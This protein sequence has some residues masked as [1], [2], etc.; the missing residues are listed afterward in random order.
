[1]MPRPQDLWLSAKA[2]MTNG[3]YFRDD[4]ASK[5]RM[6]WL[7]FQQTNGVMGN[8]VGGY[9]LNGLF[10]YMG[11]D[12]AFITGVGMI[13]QATNL[14]QLVAPLLME[15]FQKRKK[16]LL[17]LYGM[18]QLTNLVVLGLIPF[19]PA[20]Q[21]MRLLIV[22]VMIVVINTFNALWGPGS[23]I[24]QL[25][26]LTPATRTRWFALHTMLSGF[27]VA[28]FNLIGSRV[29]DAFTAAGNQL[30][31]LWLLRF[32]TIAIA[33]FNI[34]LLARNRE[35]PYEQKQGGFSVRDMV[36]KSLR[37]KKY[38]LTVGIAVCWSFIAN[39]S[40]FYAVYLQGDLKI[41]YSLLYL[42]NMLNLPIMFFIT[43]IWARLS[44]RVHWYVIVA[45]CMAGHAVQHFA[46]PFVTTSSILVY[47]IAAIFVF[48]F[49][50]GINLAFANLP[51]INIPRE[52]QTASMG[53]YSTVNCLAALGGITV[54]RFLIQ[55]TAG[56]TLTLFGLEMVGSQY[57]MFGSS[58]MLALGGL[59]CLLLFK[60]LKRTYG[61][62]AESE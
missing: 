53:F 48:F 14:L 1:M 32:V 44:K 36:Q 26:S 60:K 7:V 20:Q 61:V 3:W 16:L 46:L 31:G 52:N 28:V 45:I 13:T 41:S 33:V 49:S 9:F 8:L 21:Q 17:F 58:F 30:A 43:P 55:R 29:V 11:G 22:N 54:G 57:L 62:E 47:A 19:V 23:A 59:I 50:N 35:L 15:R 51:Y 6:R 4:E 27:L 18:L 42:I 40:A 56:H 24:W 34:F 38:L 10:L 37:E 5:D 39:L 25:Q 2:S 12:A